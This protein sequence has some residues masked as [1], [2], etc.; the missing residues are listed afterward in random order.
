M[1]QN[2]VAEADTMD[3]LTFKYLKYNN[4]SEVVR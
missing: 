2:A 4:V 3:R 1:L